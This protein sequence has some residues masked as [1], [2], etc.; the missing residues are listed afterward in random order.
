MANYTFT[1]PIVSE[2]PIGGHRLFYF[3]EMNKGVSIVKYAGVYS[4]VRY[5]MDSYLNE[6][7]EAYLGGHKHTVDEAT[8]AALIAGGIGVTEANFT[9]Q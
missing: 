8:K 5:P 2:G 3:S 4:Q 9:A 1:T 7:Q 6:A